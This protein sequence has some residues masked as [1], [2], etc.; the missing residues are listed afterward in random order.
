MDE[1]FRATTMRVPVI[2]A[3]ALALATLGG[4][5][6]EPAKVD[7]RV[8]VRMITV[9][10]PSYAAGSATPPTYAG[11]IASSFESDIAFRVPGRVVARPAGLG[12]SVDRG[13][14][15]AALDPA[16][17]R[18]AQQAAAAQVTA[19]AADA[20]QARSDVQRN[21]PLATD[22]IVPPAQLDRLRTQ[23]DTARARLA[24]ARS[25]AA[26]ARDDLGYATLRSPTSGVVT[27]V[28]VEVGQFL[29]AGQVAF[30]VARPGSLDAVV[31]V[32]EGVVAA[33]RPGVPAS[34][35]VAGQASLP[36]RIREVAPAAD[37]ATRTYRVKV[38]LDRPG[39]A[40]IGMTA[41]VRFSAAAAPAGPATTSGTAARL[42]L[43][44]LF[45]FRGRPSVWVARA[46][47][48]LEA[49]PI[50]V[51]GY[52]RDA[53]AVEGVRSGDRVV[54]AGVHRLDPS[55]KVKPWDGR[56]P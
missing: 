32:P 16:P 55:L 4:C 23:A 1:A 11:A 9:G 39:P 42:P 49:R 18:L 26:A 36:G 12:S 5:S 10:A 37:P 33:L 2:G 21:A 43:S 40:R 29:S 24:E 41:R 52:D 47:G 34:V 22:R 45:A 54:T 51:T 25:R 50:H 20:A 13:A 48:S 14:V 19:A 31:D 15:L 27:Q 56:L 38:A 6:G 46:D 35:E 44:A 7:R 3:C 30:R 53:M 28:N 8:P 17:F